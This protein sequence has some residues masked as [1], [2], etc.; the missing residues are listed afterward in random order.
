MWPT[1]RAIDR[2]GLA[3]FGWAPTWGFLVLVVLSAARWPSTATGSAT[4]TGWPCGRVGTIPRTGI[5]V[6]NTSFGS[7]CSA[8]IENLKLERPATASQLRVIEPAA[9]RGHLKLKSVKL[10]GAARLEFIGAGAFYSC[11]NLVQL[12]LSGAAALREIGGSLSPSAWPCTKFLCG[13][14]RDVSNPAG[15]AFQGSWKLS[16]V[17]LDGTVSLATIGMAAFLTTASLNQPGLLAAIDLSSSVALTS[18][19]DHAF[20]G[21]DAL[22]SVRF[23]RSLMVIGKSAF[24]NCNITML[25]LPIGSE[26]RRI[27]NDG[28]RHIS[29]LERVDLSAATKLATIG[30]RA[31]QSCRSLR[32]VDLTGTRSLARVGSQAF[33]FCTSLRSLNFAGTKLVRI[34]DNAFAGTTRLDV[35]VLPSTVISLGKHTLLGCCLHGTDV[36]TDIFGC[37]VNKAECSTVV[38]FHFGNLGVGSSKTVQIP[39]GSPG[40]QYRR[41][42][43][44]ETVNQDNW[45]N[46]GTMGD[47]LF[48]IN[49]D[50][51]SVTATRIG[52]VIGGAYSTALPDSVGPQIDLWV[53]CFTEA[54]DPAPIAAL[55]EKLADNIADSI[56]DNQSPQSAVQVSGAE[57]AVR[58]DVAMGV[59]PANITH[60]KP[61]SHA[62]QHFTVLKVPAQVTV[63]DVG[64]F[65]RNGLTTLGFDEDAALEWIGDHAFAGSKRLVSVNMSGVRNLTLGIG[66]HAFAECTALTAIVFPGRIGQI[67]KRAFYR[68]AL[69]SVDLT[70]T[71]ISWIDSGA[72]EDC[73]RLA[74]VRLPS[75]VTMIG[76][77]AFARASLLQSIDFAELAKLAMISPGTFFDCT[78]LVS[79]RLGATL[80][81]IGAAAFKGC[82]E[83]RSVSFVGPVTVDLENVA[84]RAFEGCTNLQQ[85]SFGR[86][87]HLRVIEELAF[88]ACTE[89]EAVDLVHAGAVTVGD[90]AFAGCTSLAWAGFQVDPRVNIGIDIFAGCANLQSVNLCC[91]NDAISARGDCFPLAGTRLEL[92]LTA[93]N[94]VTVVRERAHVCSAISV[95]LP[96]GIEV[97]HRDVGGASAVLRS[98]TFPSTLRVMGASAFA[99]SPILVSADLS[100][101]ANSLEEV[102][103]KAFHNCSNLRSLDL[104]G[105]SRLQRI[106]QDAV[107]DCPMFRSLLL[108]D[109]VLL[110]SIG[111]HAFSWCSSLHYVSVAGA[112]A[113]TSLGN[114]TF[115]HAHM[116]QVLDLSGSPIAEIPDSFCNNCKGLRTVKL[117]KTYTRINARAFNRCGKL[118]TI[119]FGDA[120]QLQTIGEFAFQKC[121]ALES[122]D[123]SS[124]TR[125]SRID[126]FAFKYCTNLVIVLVSDILS[127]TGAGSFAYTSLSQQLLTV[128]VCCTYTN[129]WRC[130]DYPRF[131][132]TQAAFADVGVNTVVTTIRV[133]CSTVSLKASNAS[134]PTLTEGT[135]TLVTLSSD[136][137]WTS[138]STDTVAT[139]I[140]T[141]AG[142]AETHRSSNGQDLLGLSATAIGVVIV[143]VLL[144][145][146]AVVVA[147]L[148]VFRRRQRVAKHGQT[149]RI[150][151][152]FAVCEAVK[153]RTRLKFLSDYI[154]LS[155]SSS[156]DDYTAQVAELEVPRRFV[157]LRHQ[158]GQGS[159]GLINVAELQ[160]RETTVAGKPALSST[161]VAVKS[162]LASDT[163][164]VADEALLLEALVLRALR[165]QYVVKLVGVVTR[166]LP[167]MVCTELMAGG[168]L[169]MFLRACRP[170]KQNRRAT[171]TLLDIATMGERVGV[172]MAFLETNK[173]VHRDIAAR[174]VLV[175]GSPTDVKIAD[176][177]AARSVFRVAGGA[178]VATQEHTPARWMAPEALREAKF[179]HKADVWSFGVLLWELVSFAKTPYGALGVREIVE[180]LSTGERLPEQVFTPPGFR[181]ISLLCWSEKP[182]RRP[183]FAALAPQLASIRG[184]LAAS[185]DGA[186]TLRPDN[187]LS[188]DL[189]ERHDLHEDASQ[190]QWTAT[191][192]DGPVNM[193]TADYET[194]VAVPV[195]TPRDY[196]IPLAVTTSSSGC[197]TLNVQFQAPPVLVAP[198]VAETGSEDNDLGRVY[199]IGVAPDETRL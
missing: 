53:L 19:A 149:H 155:Q 196:E 72:F 34:G 116:I 81:A 124:A 43:C 120:S 133:D 82:S 173:I 20:W 184:A 12:D 104:T 5:T 166:Q 136:R 70:G 194:A 180:M 110:S 163:S 3:V 113:L 54:G 119:D 92:L 15:G 164:G 52:N 26:L 125:L 45:G 141:L 129:T 176:L 75:T 128:W 165:H 64:A 84:A 150:E 140:S 51:E 146:L 60:I 185:P 22:R 138:D 101:A 73:A 66:D 16:D 71:R 29:S 170:A 40:G 38:P 154:H 157:K 87:P 108:K 169:K 143:V 195:P 50:S 21:G 13:F 115:A 145:V 1:V 35:L 175:G 135:R 61:F 90:R 2:V 152:E 160:H 76:A 174:N 171:L 121:H 8:M 94:K 107:R 89:L 36:E 88:A 177:G 67:G 142:L 130:P 134:Q 98:V 192:G 153:E 126:Q 103:D 137:L 44:P 42:R 151:L 59:L 159:Q 178:Y 193:A 99:G 114:G 32:E 47:D 168:D 144:V 139:V 85:F 186:I 158:I 27:G 23:P 111:A 117:P 109:T 17:R 167:F 7:H 30:D 41:L 96:E 112:I 37:C 57:T 197:N 161:R 24:R 18:I 132:L 10:V 11:P 131:A 97:V 147:G 187:E 9:F 58:C 188:A 190:V 78:E 48:R 83:L 198:V 25:E 63:I 189:T 93:S 46:A 74:V 65:S 191:P 105:H 31:F 49:L 100:A 162:A 69:E 148:L 28:F 156:I 62:R 80:R 122:L 86:M 181:K 39:I 182:S 6:G 91:H 79:V 127:S 14:P 123:L 179:T 68:A 77:F 102:D 106:G 199:S 183:G 172:A 55:L 118:H 56:A 4:G 33:Q 95:I